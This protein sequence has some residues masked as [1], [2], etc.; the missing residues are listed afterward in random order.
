MLQRNTENVKLIFPTTGPKNNNNPHSKTTYNYVDSVV[1]I[2]LAVQCSRPHTQRH[3]STPIPSFHFQM[4]FDL[5]PGVGLLACPTFHVSLCPS[6]ST[7]PHWLSAFWSA[8]WQHMDSR[9]SLVLHP[10]R[11]QQSVLEQQ[12]RRVLTHKPHLSCFVFHKN[13]SIR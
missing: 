9:T 7:A 4:A 13:T 12:S 3:R 1:H 11:S 6:V 2:L 5:Q 8:A 10:P